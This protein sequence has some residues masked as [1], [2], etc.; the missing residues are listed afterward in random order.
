MWFMEAAAATVGAVLATLNS[1]VLPAAATG[2]IST[3]VPDSPIGHIADPA[4]A[5][6]LINPT[7]VSA[8]VIGVTF[9]VKDEE[10]AEQQQPPLGE[11][12]AASVHSKQRRGIYNGT[13]AAN[14]TATFTTSP[15]QQLF[16]QDRFLQ[17][18]SAGSPDLRFDSVGFAGGRVKTVQPLLVP[19]YLLPLP[20]YWPMALFPPCGGDND[21]ELEQ[22]QQK[23]MRPTKRIS[24]GNRML[25]CSSSSSCSW[26]QLLPP[27]LG[28][29]NAAVA[30][31]A[32][33]TEQVMPLQPT[34][35]PVADRFGYPS[36]PTPS[37]RN[38]NWISSRDVRKDVFGNPIRWLLPRKARAGAQRGTEVESGEDD[39]GGEKEKEGEEG[40][41]AA[42]GGP[43]QW[44]V[45]AAGAQRR[46]AASTGST[47][48][49]EAASS[50]GHRIRGFMVDSAEPES[51]QY[52]AHVT[53]GL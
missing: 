49:P 1:S 29:N 20:H 32:P 53:L 24:K 30:A 27:Q 47:A 3:T 6:E 31:A 12:V 13:N 35:P 25:R 10:G 2:S 5:I 23:R 36:V 28:Y 51:L 46:R 37:V 4:V 7:T 50:S 42:G 45:D 11:Q 52:L 19:Q 44:R 41:P 48:A 14:N 39:D 21:E 16:Q 15:Q 40:S 9:A 18:N 22:M 34:S 43:D 38:Q 33:P 17:P 26:W 8:P